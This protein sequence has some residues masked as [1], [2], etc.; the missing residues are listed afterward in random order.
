MALSAKSRKR[1]SEWLRVVAG[2]VGGLLN[3]LGIMATVVGVLAR[4]IRDQGNDSAFTPAIHLGYAG[5]NGLAFFF[6]FTR[7]ADEHEDARVAVAI[8]AGG[9][10]ALWVSYWTWAL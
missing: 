8:W 2:L 10:V 4:G 1:R 9:T 7:M 5:L 3:A 6:L